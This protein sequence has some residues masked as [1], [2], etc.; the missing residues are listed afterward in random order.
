MDRHT[1]APII[2]TT[3][4]TAPVTEDGGENPRSRPGR[5]PRRHIGAIVACS[6][7]AGILAALLL[8]AAPIVPAQES[9]VIG[10]VLCGFAL[11]W[12]ILAVLSV[13]LTDQPQ[14]WAAAPALFMGLGGLLLVTFGSSVH[15]WLDWV[16]PPALLALAIWM[17][18]HV[19]RRLRSRSGRWLLYPVIALT[20]LASVGG[21]YETVSEA[22]DAQAYP[23]PAG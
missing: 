3:N 7:A 16:W 19:H 20:A 6:L 1:R 17:T 22:T 2:M 9:A 14:R 10:A 8:V 15:R 18:V 11:G 5:G 4:P 21:G 13:R 23:M 12:A